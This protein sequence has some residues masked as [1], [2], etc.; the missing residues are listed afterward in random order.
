[1]FNCI[2]Y[3][4][5]VFIFFSWYAPANVGSWIFLNTPYLYRIVIEVLPTAAFPQRTNLTAF[6]E[7]LGFDRIFDLLGSFD[8]FSFL[9]ESHIT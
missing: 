1:M 2:S 5:L 3:P 7:A 6:L 9:H 4:F 8:G